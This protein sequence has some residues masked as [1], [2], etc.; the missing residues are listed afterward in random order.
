VALRQG[1]ELGGSGHYRVYAKQSHRSNTETQDGT[2]V[3]DASH[4]TQLGFRADWAHD[5][6]RIT[7]QGDA[8]TGKR[9]Q[10]L[11]GSIS[12]TGV[13]LVLGAI[14]VS[15]GN[16]LARW[17]HRLADDAAVTAQASYDRVERTVPPTFAE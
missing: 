17:E 13:D 15:G 4:T 6:D 3:D 8:Y 12:I 11:P 14:S 1:G 10:P 9:Q 16:L 5:A 7:F 2:P